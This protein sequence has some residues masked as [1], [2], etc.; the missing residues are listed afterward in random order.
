[1]TTT[2]RQ[3]RQ[4][5]ATA[6]A[7]ERL[8]RALESATAN[9][10]YGREER[11]AELPGS[12][13]LRD[14][15]KALRSATLAR[16]AD[17]L[18][19]FER[20]ATAAGSRVHWAAD[21]EA[22]CRI[23]VDIARQHGV[24]LV[25]KSKS[26]ASEEI[27]LNQA[28][29]AAGIEPVETD[30]GEWI[31]QL[32][33]E[34][35][36]HIIAPAVHKTRAQIAELF[37]EQSLEHPELSEGPTPLPGDEI[38]PL[39]DFARSTLRQR[40]LAAGMGVTGG[41]LAVAE[42]GS[43]VLVTNEGNGRLVSSLPLVVVS[44][45]GIEKLCPTWDDAAAWLTLLPRAATGQPIAVYTSILSGP[46]RPGDPDGPREVHIVL[47]DNGRSQQIGGPF[48]E[49][50][51]C[52]RCSACLNIC[53]VYREAGGHAYGSP[54]S[55]PIGAVITP[56]LY[57]LADYEALP[58]AS[59]LCGAC[60]EACPVRIDLPRMLLEWRAQEVEQRIIPA[61]ER[62]LERGVAFVMGHRR[63]WEL[64]TG[65]GRL[66][67]KPL[68]RNGHLRLPRRLNPVRP[69]QLPAL[70]PRSFR[71]MWAAGELDE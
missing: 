22:A 16:L 43:V 60:L 23:V 7:D 19:A 6:I 56:W 26:M 47:L 29:Q 27:H 11:F 41:N 30:L 55:G 67:Q 42:T 5:A 17:H 49:S 68:A 62:L 65:L 40:F 57:G 33:G 35:P 15:F 50:L 45:V 51:Q 25:T 59:S 71:E 38:Q 24:K 44:V 34:P 53:P 37:N 58:Q 63:L 1:M 8:Q 70:A 21:A 64:A 12:E 54:Y 46:A 36:S 28:L 4:G 9:F 3:F 61:G 52:I 39:L 14:H 31:I 20:N 2:F 32:A 69:R 10:R 66:L 48:E 18:E 13:P